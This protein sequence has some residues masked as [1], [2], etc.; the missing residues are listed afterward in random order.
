LILNS[1]PKLSD[2]YTLSQTGWLGGVP[3]FEEGGGGCAGFSCR[4]YGVFR[5]VPVFL[6]VLHAIFHCEVSFGRKHIGRSKSEK[7]MFGRHSHRIFPE[8]NTLIIEESIPACVRT[9]TLEETNFERRRPQ[10]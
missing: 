1:G 5:D 10:K 8:N 6:E 4:C 3:G 9:M 7:N 2:F